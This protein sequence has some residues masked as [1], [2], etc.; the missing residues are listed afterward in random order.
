M[1]MGEMPDM[2]LNRLFGVTSFEI[3]GGDEGI[4][5]PDL[6]VANAALSHLSY[7]P[8]NRLAIWLW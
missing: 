6:G 5:T 3:I 7:I 4:R 2:P 8:P 1:Y